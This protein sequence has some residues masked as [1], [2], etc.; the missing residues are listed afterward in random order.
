MIQYLKGQL[1]EVYWG[2]ALIGFWQVSDPRKLSADT[3][4]ACLTGLNDC[5]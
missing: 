1:Q 3:F 2:R 5:A 4:G